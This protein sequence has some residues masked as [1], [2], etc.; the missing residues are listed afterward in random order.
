MPCRSRVIGRLA[1]GLLLI[2]LSECEASVTRY[3]S[4]GMPYTLLKDH[5]KTAGQ[6]PNEKIVFRGLPES[7]GY[8]GFIQSLLPLIRDLPR[9]KRPPIGI[10]PDAFD[11]AG[12]V[13]V[14][15]IQEDGHKDERAAIYPVTEPDPR[16]R[17]RMALTR[18]SLPEW[19]AALMR[20]S[21]IPQAAPF[22]R[23][24]KIS[25][26]RIEPSFHLPRSL[27]NAEGVVLA[28]AGATLNPLTR[29]PIG[30]SLLVM[31]VGESKSI[32]AVR[33]R[34]KDLQGHAQILVAGLNPGEVDPRL[35]AIS[36]LFQGPAYPI[37]RRWLDQ[38]RITGLPAE[39]RSV[40]TV[41]EVC[42]WPP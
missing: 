38:L 16:I 3:V 40:G 21:P 28:K 1:L 41:L 24:T 34:F 4:F 37:P 9:D 32:D 17:M 39:V 2:G 36:R 27:Q 19:E 35:E 23:A 11:A 6:H 18:L 29:L 5:F 25:C 30:V 33:E 20:K 14:P 22:P 10:D 15:V 12:I 7:M 8:T 42:Q 31:E 26:H 13:K